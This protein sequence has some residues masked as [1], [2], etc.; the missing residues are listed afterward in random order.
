MCVNVHKHTRTLQNKA[1]IQSLLLLGRKAMTNLDNI[2]KSKDITL[3]T[4][5]C[6][7]KVMFFPV[8][9]YRCVSWAI[10]KGWAL[11]NWCLQTAVL[12]KTLESPLDSNEIKPLNPKGNQPWKFNERTDA[13]TEAPVLWPPDAKKQL[14]GKDPDAAKD[15]EQ[16]KREQKRM[17]CSTHIIDSMDMNL[18]KLQDIVKDGEAWCAAVHGVAKSWTQLSD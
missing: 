10:T 6:I 15:W 11:K 17:R 14:I 12:E 7:V 16:E 1:M 9:M 5:G 4:K 8:V 2:F 3:L 18:S 13:E